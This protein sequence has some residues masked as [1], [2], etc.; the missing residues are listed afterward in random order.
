MNIKILI[1]LIL[2]TIFAPAN[3]HQHN[4]AVCAIFQ[5]E[6]RFLKEW[7]EFNILI[8][9]EHFY[10]YNNYSTDNYLEI[11]KPYIDAGIVDCIDWPYSQEGCIQGGTIVAANQILSEQHCTNSIPERVRGI[12]QV[13][14]Y[15]HCL[16]NIQDKVKWLMLIDIDEFL[17]PVQCDNLTTFLKDYEE[18]AAV[19]A[20]WIHFGT[21]DI[22]RIPYN[23]LLIESLIMREIITEQTQ[24]YVKSIVQPNKIKTLHIHTATEFYLNYFQVNP[25]KIKFEGPCQPVLKTTDKLRINHYWTRDKEFLYNTKIPRQYFFDKNYTKEWVLQRAAHMNKRKDL[26]IQKYVSQLREKVLK[27]K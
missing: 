13:L 17:F 3:A 15:N 1:Y 12:A 26:T 18:F 27:T 8:G 22:D 14:A 10:L 5:N 25:N 23:K 20:T 21:S 24:S 16:D 11:L 9:V 4:L 6:G 19:C 7:L 2:F